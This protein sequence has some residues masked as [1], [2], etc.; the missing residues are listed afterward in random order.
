MIP[1]PSSGPI[2]APTAAPP[3]RLALV[4]A[5]GSGKT[6]LGRWAAQH[7]GL[8]FTDLDDVFWR[9]GW[10]KA[11]LDVFRAEVDRLTSQPRWVLAGN[12][13]SARDLIWPRAD[14][15]LWLD[16][17]LALTLWRSSVRVWRQTRSR[18]PICNGNRQTLS[19]LFFGR[20]PLLWYAIKTVPVRRREWPLLLAAP[21]HR[22]LNIARMKSAAAVR[23]WQAAAL[24]RLG[25]AH[26]L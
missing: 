8:P 10:Q 16:L 19:A 2:A 22:H 9:P 23:R 5:S 12:Y 1:L 18:E 25:Q 13:S 6:T 20:D 24:A 4:G 11:P 26:V 15:L 3:Q 17:P 14:T 21:E 7:L